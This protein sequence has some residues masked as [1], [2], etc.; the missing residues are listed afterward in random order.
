M[1]A[2]G[3]IFHFF[4]ISDVDIRVCDVCDSEVVLRGHS[5]SPRQRQQLW[6][7]LWALC[8]QAYSRTLGELSSTIHGLAP[9]VMS[10]RAEQA[11]WKVGLSSAQ[12]SES[13]WFFPCLCV[14]TELEVMVWRVASR[15]YTGL[16]SAWRSDVHRAIWAGRW[17]DPMPSPSCWAPGDQIPQCRSLVKVLSFSLSTSVSRGLVL[18]LNPRF[19]Y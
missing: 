18:L 5:L 1:L 15:V 4:D 3:W 7:R 19:S 2:L 8:S 11:F 6:G 9:S 10:Y 12:L 17:V 13:F 14:W 16:A